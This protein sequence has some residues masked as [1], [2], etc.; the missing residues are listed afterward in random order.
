[1]L[2]VGQIEDVMS[3]Y[4]VVDPPKN[5]I[6]LDKPAARIVGES[7]VFYKGLQPKWRGDV[8]ILTPLDD[9]ETVLH[10]QFHAQYGVPE[11]V[12]DVLGKF[13]VKKIR[14]LSRRP[15]LKSLSRTRNVHYTQC[16]GCEICQNLGQLMMQAPPGARPQHYL[17][18]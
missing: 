9:E 6:L 8:V 11:P 2:T 10:E 17:L 14:V 3:K 4:Y 1:M 16:S 13:F 7:V 15:V 12:A 5:L 18:D